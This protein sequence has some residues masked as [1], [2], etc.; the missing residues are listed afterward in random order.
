M[1]SDLHQSLTS[2][3]SQEAVTPTQA[4]CQIGLPYLQ[5]INCCPC[6]PEAANITTPLNHEKWKLYL[7][8]HPDAALTEFFIT[9]LT[10]GF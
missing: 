10:Q 6:P 1:I 8:D 7:S 5:H 2:S 4:G 3:F 9:G